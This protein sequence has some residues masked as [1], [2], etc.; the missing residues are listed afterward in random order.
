MHACN[1][2]FEIFVIDFL[3]LC[4]RMFEE[5][6]HLLT[7]QGDHQFRVVLSVVC[8]GIYIV[9]FSLSANFETLP[10]LF[11]E[12]FLCVLV[13]AWTLLIKVGH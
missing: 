8:Q 6:F 7:W 3:L 12:L 2:L 1:E 5:F 11:H 9:S 4:Y 10:A 13:S